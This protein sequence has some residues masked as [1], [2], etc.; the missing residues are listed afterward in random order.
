MVHFNTLPYSCFEFFIEKK[1]KKQ[2]ENSDS[3]DEAPLS[4]YRTQAHESNSTEKPIE[5]AYVE[6]YVKQ[7]DARLTGNM[8]QG[9]DQQ[10]KSARSTT[11]L[12]QKVIYEERMAMLQQLNTAE[13]KKVEELQKKLDAQIAEMK[14]TKEEHRKVEAERQRELEILEAD[15][16]QLL[17][18]LQ[19]EET[20]QMLDARQRK[21]QVSK[22]MFLDYAYHIPS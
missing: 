16:S 17:E 10:D 13:K 11:T 1:N 12:P 19:A 14:R 9:S 15:K 22:L 7:R 18:A 2:T 8:G 21:E 5:A 3:D 4:S 6:N 20:R